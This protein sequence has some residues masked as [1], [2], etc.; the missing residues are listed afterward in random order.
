MGE[1]SAA[2]TPTGASGPPGR[3]ALAHLRAYFW[4]AVALVA[5][6]AAAVV[7]LRRQG[8]LWWC[9]CGRPDL[10]WGDTRSAHN[11]QHLFDPYSFTH[12]LHG[13][14]LCGLLSW[15]GRRLLPPWRLCVAVALEALWEVIENTDFV[16][17]RYRTVTASL[18]Y[19]GDTVANSLGDILSCVVG[20][21]LARRLGLWWSLALFAAT[22]AVL[23]LWLRDS[24]LLNVVMLVHP[25]DAIKRW[26]TGS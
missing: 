20:F 13:I 23:L 4:P 2:K 14:L 24:L 18:G 19:H 21:L 6:L 3:P 1:S 15:A 26:Q 12:V 17:N 8:R 16:I 22:E 25:V 11:S 5:I 7:E 9:A 10:W